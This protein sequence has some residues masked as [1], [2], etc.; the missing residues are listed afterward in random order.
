M[1]GNKIIMVITMM[2][3]TM[4]VLSLVVIAW[5]M[6]IPERD[7]NSISGLRSFSEAVGIVTMV[8]AMCYGWGTVITWED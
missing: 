2:C 3:M 1:D 8:L 7:T 6:V 5:T 4:G